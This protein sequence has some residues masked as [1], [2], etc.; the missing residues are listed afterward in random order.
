M[1]LELCEEMGRHIPERVGAGTA[2]PAGEEE[3]TPAPRAEPGAALSLT[4]TDLVLL[5]QGSTNKFHDLKNAST[6]LQKRG[7]K[8]VFTKKMDTELWCLFSPIFSF[9]TCESYESV[10]SAV[11]DNQ[12]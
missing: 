5:A 10:P 12:L 6:S 11:L 8:S 1:V 4:L 9:P 3:E 2:A 7:E